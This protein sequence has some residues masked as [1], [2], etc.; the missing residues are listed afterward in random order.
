MLSRS[1]LSS[2]SSSSSAARRGGV[3]AAPALPSRA[4][5]SGNAKNN[6]SRSLAVRPVAALAT[7]DNKPA[8]VKVSLFDRSLCSD[9]VGEGEEGPEGHA[10]AAHSPRRGGGRK[11]VSSSSGEKTERRQA[12]GSRRTTW[13]VFKR[14]KKTLTFFFFSLSFFQTSVL[15]FPRSPTASAS[16]PRTASSALP[17]SL[18]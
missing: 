5:L 12:S 4:G 7:G 2:V 6:A 10:S 18:R 15:F 17:R 16:R 13:L 14:E 9:R 11:T 1:A 8:V 3:A